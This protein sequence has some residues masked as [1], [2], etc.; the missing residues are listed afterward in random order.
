[1]SRLYDV[2][3]EPAAQRDIRRLDRQVRDRVGPHITSLDEDPTPVGCVKLSGTRDEFRL[4]VGGW[5]V[6]YT[7]DHSLRVVRIKRVVH[8]SKAY[9]PR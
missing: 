4:R 6:L 9:P 3:V 1:M 2:W 8:R 7:V 5:R